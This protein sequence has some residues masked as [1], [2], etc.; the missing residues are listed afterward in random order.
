MIVFTMLF[1]IFAARRRPLADATLWKQQLSKLAS[2][3]EGMPEIKQKRRIR[4]VSKQQSDLGTES[5]DD[6]DGSE[7]VEDLFTLDSGWS[8]EV[9]GEEDN[10]DLYEI[11]VRL[12]LFNAIQSDHSRLLRLSAP[13]VAPKI[14]KGNLLYI[15]RRW[16]CRTQILMMVR[17]SWAWHRAASCNPY[18]CID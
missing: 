10:K 8:V 11:D 1:G 17:R 12:I 14:S 15:S 18:L 3:D 13:L 6:L 4:H 2:E 16:N 5:P 7:V 9:L